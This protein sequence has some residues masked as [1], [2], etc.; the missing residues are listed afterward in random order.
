VAAPFGSI[1]GKVSGMCP[2]CFVRDVPGLPPADCPHPPPPFSVSADSKEVSIL[3][4][5][6]ESTLAGVLVSV[7][8][9]GFAG[10]HNAVLEVADSGRER[11]GK[12][13]LGFWRGGGIVRNEHSTDRWVRDASVTASYKEHRLKP[14]L[15][16]QKRQPVAAVRELSLF[17][18]I[19]QIGGRCKRQ[20]GL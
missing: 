15:P 1:P 10:K 8:F 20:I 11:P 3:V 4:S 7:D 16:K 13:I 18:R 5:R 17:A 19:H 6:L 9:N 2:V 12:S 14:V